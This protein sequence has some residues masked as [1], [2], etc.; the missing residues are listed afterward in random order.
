MQG[1]KLK[2]RAVVFALC[3]GGVAFFLSLLV[4]ANGSLAIGN[5]ARAFIPAMVCAVMCWASAHRAIGATAEAIDIAVDRLAGAAR[6]DLTSA[7][8]PAVGAAV[9]ELSAAMDGLFTQMGANLE[10]VQRLALFD[11]VTGLPNRT[12]FRRT[13]ERLLGEVDADASAALLFI[14]LDRFKAVNDTRGHAMGD[15]L[16]GMVANRLRAVAD[17]AVGE[18]GASAPMIGRLA[19]DEFTLFFPS[20][21]DPADAMWIGRSVLFALGEEFDLGDVPVSIGASVG[22]AQRPLHGTTLHELMRAAD[23]AMY[24]AKALGRGRVECFSDALA[25]EIADRARLDG[26]LRRAI[27]NRQF[28]LAFQPQIHLHRDHV[29]AA[30]AL[31]RWHHPSLGLRMPGS[32]IDRAEENGLIVEIGDWVVE[33][34]SETIARWGRAGVVQRLA[35]NVSPRQIENAGFFRRLRAAMYEAQAPATLLELE[36]TETLAMGC[37]ADV[38]RAISAL[39]S[40]GATIAIDGFGTGFSNL[41]QL[42]QMPI[43]RIKLDRTLIAPIAESAEARTIAQAVIALIH[44]LN[45]EA[46]AEGIE[47]MAQADV[48]RVIGCDVIQGYAVAAPMD[49]DAFLD[50]SRK[51]ERWT[52]NG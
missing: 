33:T 23:I 37:S 31:L 41:S 45:C 28:S 2:N 38:L 7:V 15:M 20:L 34:V 4:T 16:L 42:R 26:E 1:A 14:D 6:G 24:H 12:H 17:R 11:P 10:S 40:D 47:T 13:C 51:G 52:V 43:D 8:P 36:I 9:P 49:E 39:R 32:F 35:I 30:E 19:G 3:A 46:V 18:A 50:W 27:D 5:Y 29:V 21:R 44:G 22:V 25:A 48:L